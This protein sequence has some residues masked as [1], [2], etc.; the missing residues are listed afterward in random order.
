MAVLLGIVQIRLATLTTYPWE[1]LRSNLQPV[2][3][4]TS[5][6]AVLL[7]IVRHTRVRLNRKVG[8]IYS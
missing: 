3:E 8:W 2:R 6:M 5:A 7:N 1:Y 4:T